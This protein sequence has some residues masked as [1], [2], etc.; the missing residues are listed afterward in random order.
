MTRTLPIMEARKKLNT[1]PETLMRDGEIDVME[2]TRRG[3]PVLAVLPWELYEAITETLEV[4][5][6]KQTMETLRQSV[7]ELEQGTFV[8]WDDAKAEL[9]K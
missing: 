5:A 6:D 4:M 2:I 9:D 8:S 7:Q 3:K 1:L